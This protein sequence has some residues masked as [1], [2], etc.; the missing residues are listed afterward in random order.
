MKIKL[1]EDYSPKTQRYWGVVIG[2]ISG[3]LITL[4]A[5]GIYTSWAMFAKAPWWDV[6]TA[7]GTVGA[8]VG[9]VWIAVSDRYRSRRASKIKSIIYVWKIYPFLKELNR[10]FSKTLYALGSDAPQRDKLAEDIDK[11]VSQI[12]ILNFESLYDYHHT[13][14]VNIFQVRNGLKGL[15]ALHQNAFHDDGVIEHSF[16]AMLEKIKEARFIIENY[17]GDRYFL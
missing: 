16:G 5:Q 14:C 1:S 11:L 9:A 17:K 3:V 6:M 15:L 10:F 12:E 4:L 8:A 13:V 2:V 7:F